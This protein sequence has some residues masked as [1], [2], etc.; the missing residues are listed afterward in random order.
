MQMGIQVLVDD[1]KNLEKIRQNECDVLKGRIQ[2]IL[3]AGANVI[4]TK[5][6]LDDIASKYLIEAGAIGIRR[7]EKGD[8][9][10]IAKLTGAT[11]ISTM[12]TPEGE[13]VFEESFLG[14]C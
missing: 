12:A 11:V 3:N 4:L 8:L 10:R 7:V 14:E 5:M 13:E 1:P 6:G 2:K 9:S